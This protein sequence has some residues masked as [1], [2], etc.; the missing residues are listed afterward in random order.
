[1]KRC[2]NCSDKELKLRVKRCLTE[3]TGFICTCGNEFNKDYFETLNNDKYD[4][5]VK[6]EC[7]VCSGYNY[8][9][10]DNVSVLIGT[11]VCNESEEFEVEIKE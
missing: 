7:E 1:M 8:E 3:L 5:A 10:N 4:K 11:C 9:F 2:R 6:V